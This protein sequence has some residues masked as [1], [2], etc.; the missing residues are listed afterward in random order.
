ML[1]LFIPSNIV[2]TK[3]SILRDFVIS[4]IFELTLILKIFIAIY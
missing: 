3:R 1:I 4:I 2:N